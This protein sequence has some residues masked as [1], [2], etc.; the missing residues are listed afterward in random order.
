M[1]KLI[2]SSVFAGL[3]LGGSAVEA[4]TAVAPQKTAYGK[5]AINADFKAGY[6]KSFHKSTATGDSA[7][8][9]DG[10]DEDAVRTQFV[11]HDARMSFKT[12]GGCS[13]V[14]FGAFVK[15]N[16]DPSKATIRKLFRDV[17]VFARFADMI[18]V[19]VGNQR[20]AM[21]SL[22][23]GADIMGG[24]G[25]YNGNW[26]AM[27]SKTKFKDSTRE[28]Q[29]VLDLTHANDTGYTNAIE[30]R[31]MRMAGVQAVLNWKPSEA[32]AGGFGTYKDG[33][34]TL[35]RY[36]EKGQLERVNNNLVSL[37]LNYDNTFGDFRIRASAG[38]V[39]GLS[40]LTQ[41]DAATQKVVEI[42]NQPDSIVY[43]FGGIIGWNGLE[44]GAGFLDNRSTGQAPG[45]KSKEANAGKVL[46]GAIGYQFDASMK[47]RIALGAL[48]GW[49][50]GQNDE[51]ADNELKNQDVTLAVSGTFELNIRDGF[52]WFV[53][54][55]WAAIDPSNKKE[56]TDTGYGE[57][58]VIIGTGFAV[59]Q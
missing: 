17:Y 36:N 40:K 41:L 2:L 26:S 21:Y 13:A 16:M 8:T 59:S 20:D 34:E 25:G 44:F 28:A 6:W 50:N 39:Y 38:A 54:G 48:Y 11:A 29:W 45:V 52:K 1:K 14:A 19:R 30:L 46:H 31:T 57:Y 33:S 4:N 53:D 15:M 55:T 23:D 27:L 3:V 51:T 5:F 32:Y 43:R 56:A 7:A 49:C 18:E 12:E 47:P 9:W 10:F 35:S 37:G 58:N 42:A 22:V 24:T